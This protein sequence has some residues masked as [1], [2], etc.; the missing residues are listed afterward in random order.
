MFLLLQAYQN[1]VINGIQPSESFL[2]YLAQMGLINTMAPDNM[3][4]QDPFKAAPQ[5][6]IDDLLFAIYQLAQA[7]GGCVYCQ[8]LSVNYS[9]LCN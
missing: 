3:F 7:D 9:N 2:V 5:W 1:C 4:Y 8:D 6:K